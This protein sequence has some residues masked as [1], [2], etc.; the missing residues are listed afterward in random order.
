MRLPL[1]LTV[2]SP[3]HPSLHSSI[4]VFRAST[5]LC[6]TR[7]GDKPLTSTSSRY[8]K[9]SGEI[10]ESS[11]IE[12]QS[13]IQSG[14][15]SSI[16][17]KVDS[18]TDLRTNFDR[19]DGAPGTAS[20]ILGILSSPRF[21]LLSG[22]LVL[23]AS[24]AYAVDTLP[25]LPLSVTLAIQYTEAS[26]SIFFLIEYVLRLY[27]TPDRLSYI[28]SP[29]AMVDLV[30][31]LPT[32]LSIAMPGS[33]EAVNATVL[34]SLRLLRIL[35]LQRFLVDFDSFAKLEMAIGLSPSELKI[36]Q[37]QFARVFSSLFTLLYISTG[38]I[39]AAEHSVNS[40]IP[41]FF[42]ALY[43][44]LCTLT[45]VGF[46]DIVPVTF[47]GR[48]VV[49]ASIL[50]GIGVIPLQIGEL[51][52]SLLKDTENPEESRTLRQELKR[53]EAELSRLRKELEEDE[54]ELKKLRIDLRD[55]EEELKVLRRIRAEWAKVMRE[56][57]G[58]EWNEEAA[59]KVINDE[60]S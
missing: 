44:G 11:F 35:R 23:V 46:G 29:L 12:A 32:V 40:Q 13:A 47:Y 6:A 5:A 59:V 20:S 56:K 2:A 33:T 51:A 43:F 34:S 8:E 54:L 48:L 17:S 42:T 21:E 18:N 52:E 41:D 36:S 45:T 50:I 49:C 9:S 4:S 27:S 31:F 14:I 58:E 25:S 38:L 3:F 30:S 26:I 37:L 55:D 60:G 53:E 1:L 24:G 10:S 19:Q 22:A 15:N 28:F 16:D 39:Y 57:E 7:D